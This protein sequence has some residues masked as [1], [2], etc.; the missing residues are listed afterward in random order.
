M[1]DR[2]SLAATLPHSPTGP[3]VLLWILAGIP[4]GLLFTMAGELE[5]RWFIAVL[6]GTLAALF[7]FFFRDRKLYFLLL[8]AGSTSVG[9]TL[10]LGLRPDSVY[11]STHAFLVS[12]CHIPLAMVV[13]IHL[14]RSVHRTGPVSFPFG[15]LAS[16]VLLF[17]V[18]GLSVL[19][20]APSHYGLFDLF[21]LATSLAVFLTVSNVIENARELR[22]VLI[23]LVLSVAVQ[24]VLAVAQMLAASTLGLDLFG[25]PKILGS[26]AGLTRVSRAGGTL[27][28][29]NS[30]ALYMDLLLPLC[31][32]LLL[33]SK[34]M[35][36]RI[37]LGIGF[38]LGLIG[39]VATLS[40][41]GLIA[42]GLSL[43]AILIIHWTRHIGVIRSV[44]S[45]L[46]GAALVGVI[47]VSTP[48]PVQKRFS[49]Y[50]YGAGYGRYSLVL[51]SLNVIKNHPLLGVGLNNFTEVARYFDNT[52]EGIITLWNAPVHN[53]LLFIAGETGIL[54]LSAFLL[55]MCVVFA[56][57]RNSL[58]SPDPLVACTSLGLLMGFVAF[59]IHSL[60]DYC[61]W[62]HFNPLWV[63]AGLALS[64]GRVSHRAP[65]G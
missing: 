32:S 57:L 56:S 48:N 60:V 28:H 9:L 34:G 59:F 2:S 46:L 61:H 36:G 25:A 1:E 17:A 37:L 65:F 40:R 38:V 11:R 19:A 43:I 22:A 27:G 39:L 21:A 33:F 14:M 44:L 64:L 16:S 47:L 12:L 58:S 6:A 15:A 42:T 23:V 53:L 26:Y 7:S 49:T 54:G 10:H 24:G 5:R 52:P 13:A 18:C 31:L 51:V 55:L 4:A 41:G 63:Q 50:D 8:F 29:P 3:R 35:K 30:L 62:T 45:L 20:G